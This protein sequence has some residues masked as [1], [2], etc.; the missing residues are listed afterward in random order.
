MFASE[1]VIGCVAFH[2]LHSSLLS[3]SGSR[4]FDEDRGEGDSNSSDGDSTDRESDF[5]SQKIIALSKRR[6]LPSP[7]VKDS[8]LKL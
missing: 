6:P 3:V 2:P 5:E 7:Y 4:H 8:S 1:D